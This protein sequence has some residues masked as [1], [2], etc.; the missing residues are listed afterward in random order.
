MVPPRVLKG[1]VNE[2]AFCEDSIA[3]EY[4]GGVLASSRGTGSR[5]DRGVVMNA[6]IGRLSVYQLRTHYIL[7]HIIKDLYDGTGMGM[8]PCDSREMRSFLPLIAYAVAMGLHE[9][10]LAEEANVDAFSLGAILT[11][12]SLVSTRKR[13]LVTSSTVA[14]ALASSRLR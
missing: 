13:S 3:A 1:I 2:G 14:M 12:V 7:Y 5:D 10:E 8:P 11:H 6:L 4:L 9:Y